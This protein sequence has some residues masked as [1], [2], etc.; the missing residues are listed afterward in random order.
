MSKKENGVCIQAGKMMFL[1]QRL[2]EIGQN[3]KE[4]FITREEIQII[5]IREEF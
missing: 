5:L 2:Q 1:G 3:L 4:L